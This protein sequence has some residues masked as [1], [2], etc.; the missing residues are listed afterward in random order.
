ML[1]AQ[2]ARGSWAWSKTFATHEAG[3]PRPR[4]YLPISQLN[5]QKPF[6]A[7]DPTRRG[8][9]HAHAG[10][11]RGDGRDGQDTGTG[12]QR[13]SIEVITDRV[14]RAASLATWRVVV[15]GARDRGAAG[16]RRRVQCMS[17]RV[18]RIHELGVRIVLGAT[19]SDI[20]PW[21]FRAARLVLIGALLGLMG[22]AL[23]ARLLASLLFESRRSTRASMPVRGR[24]RVDRNRGDV[25]SGVARDANGSDRGVAGRVARYGFLARAAAQCGAVVHDAGSNNAGASST[26]AFHSEYSSVCTG[27]PPTLIATFVA[28][29]PPASGT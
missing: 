2:R 7:R 5:Q 15:L 1:R 16:V 26:F 8:A 10:T 19:A 17:Y 18:R 24:A 22:A 23:G 13:A 21:C 29:Q 20:V 3:A 11:R 27:A 9:D 6:D 4:F 12:R 14:N 28:N 25:G